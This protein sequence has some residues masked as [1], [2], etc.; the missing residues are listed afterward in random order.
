MHSVKIGSTILVLL[1]GF[2]SAYAQPT[3]EQCHEKAK[4]NY[5]SVQRY[6]LIQRSEQYNLSNANKGYLPQLSLSAKAT[7]QTDV[8]SLP[9]EIP[10]QGIEMPSLNKDQYQAVLEAD[11][12]LWDGGAI[13][14]QKKRTQAE[15]EVDSRQLDV[16]LY[17]LNQRVNNLYFGILLLGDQREQNRLYREE[18]QR[19]YDLV[20]SYVRN[21]VANQADLDAVQVEQLNANQQRIELE[22]NEKAYRQMLSALIGEPLGEGPLVFP[23]TDPLGG[24]RTVNRP[25]LRLFDARNSLLDAREKAV[26]AQSLPRIG[27]FVQGGYGNPGL[28]MLKNEFSPYA[29]GGVRLSWNLSVFYTKKKETLDIKIGRQTVETERET[30]LFNTALDMTRQSSEIEKWTQTMQDDDRIIAL[31][32]N[33]KRAAAAKM[34]NGTITVT[35]YLRETTAEQQARQAK[36][37]HQIQR[38]LAIY[39]LKYTANR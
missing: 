29:L 23:E 16:D 8:V 35:E 12:T 17:T 21:G 9:F 22:S 34:A 25:E 32:E 5:P 1:S 38:I 6:G 2:L 36:I 20:A 39:E 4:A 33:I 30:F 10:I 11:Q 3:V 13:R 31:R 15:A 7:Y 37:L 14:S 24:E 27:L 28:N 19:N 26:R 18:L